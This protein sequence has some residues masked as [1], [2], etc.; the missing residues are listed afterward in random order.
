MWD[1]LCYMA[2]ISE[3]CGAGVSTIRVKPDDEK[4]K[5]WI[6][7]LGIRRPGCPPCSPDFRQ[8]LRLQEEYK[9]LKPEERKGSLLDYL[10]ENYEYGED[11]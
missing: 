10:E 9:V 2:E 6:V 3:K 11:D 1:T 7:E 5:G 8:I 4:L